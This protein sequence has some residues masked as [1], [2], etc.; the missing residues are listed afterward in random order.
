MYISIL[1]IDIYKYYISK[2]LNHLYQE[3]MNSVDIL[4]DDNNKT[5]V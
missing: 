2:I 3:T 1:I 4:I 5:I